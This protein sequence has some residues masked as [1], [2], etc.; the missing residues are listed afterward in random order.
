MGEQRVAGRGGERTVNRLL[1]SRWFSICT[2]ILLGSV[3]VYSSWSKIA[4]PPGFARVIWNYRI[5]PAVLI[6]PA[7]IVLPWLELLAG[8]ALLL[9]FLRRGAALL[10]SSMLLLF[11]AALTIDLARGIPVDCGCFS[12]AAA[13]KTPAELFSS[14]KLDL[15]RDSGLLLLSLQSLFSRA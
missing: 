3:F 15:L 1:H 13:A 12:V 7:A 6:G 5:L 8:L 11:I 10:V 9:G 2:R 4:D 14:M